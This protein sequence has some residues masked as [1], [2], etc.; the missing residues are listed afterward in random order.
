[1]SYP[2]PPIIQKQVEHQPELPILELSRKRCINDLEFESV[3]FTCRA[4]NIKEAEQGI[5]FLMRCEEALKQESQSDHL[6]VS[7]NAS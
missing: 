4:K 5:L 2:Q 1:M 7:H 6:G 3:T